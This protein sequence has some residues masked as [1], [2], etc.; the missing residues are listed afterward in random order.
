MWAL[1]YART[2]AERTLAALDRLAETVG[3]VLG[4]REAFA[5]LKLYL[6]AASPYE[7]SELIEMVNRMLKTAFF[8]EE[9]VNTAEKLKQEGREEGLREGRRDVLP[10]AS[11]LQRRAGN[12][13]KR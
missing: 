7:P 12:I 2:Q 1:T 6:F 11:V 9:V 13:T 10:Q 5:I 8:R 4:E 3:E